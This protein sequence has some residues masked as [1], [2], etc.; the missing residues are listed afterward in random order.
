M[1]KGF[2]ELIKTVK[3]LKKGPVGKQV[4][5]RMS[6]FREM[7]CACRNDLFCEL[8]FCIL[9]ANCSAEAC[10]R[11]QDEVGD[12]F[13]A[14]TE[15][16]LA[17]R[18]KK[19]GYRF[20]NKRAAYIV[21]AREKKEELKKLIDSGKTGREIRGWLVDNITGLGMKEASHFLR[22]IGFGDVAII[23]FHIIDLL[24]GYGIIS[25]PESLT[26]KKY[27]KIEEKLAKLADETR[28]DLG[29]LDLYLWYLETGKILK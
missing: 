22:N 2:P 24:A 13:T 8:A 25:A 27:L 7:K 6:E 5:L 26:K 15:K 10:I 17:S 3:S 16:Q 18:L 29:K 19:L 11:V 23:D 28:L 12:G 9:T 4:D 1:K 21:S 14:L 20:P